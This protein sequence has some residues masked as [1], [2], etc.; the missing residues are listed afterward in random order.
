MHCLPL[1]L[2]HTG[3]SL[4]ALGGLLLKSMLIISPT[5]PPKGSCSLSIP[6]VD[7]VVQED[8]SSL[9]HTPASQKHVSFSWSFLCPNLTVNS[10][11]IELR[12]AQSYPQYLEQCKQPPDMRCDIFLPPPSKSF[13]GG[14]NWLDSCLDTWKQTLFLATDANQQWSLLDC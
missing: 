9:P 11:K 7:G 1:P 10:K 14:G 8:S 13:P 6:L 3:T 5:P 2:P 12:V 4:C